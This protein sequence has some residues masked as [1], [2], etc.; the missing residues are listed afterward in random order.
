VG[1]KCVLAERVPA[2]GHRNWIV[3]AES[4]C[5][6]QAR[7]GIEPASVGISAQLRLHALPL[8]AR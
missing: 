1:W 2:F 3:I 7:G 8:A 4:A 6:A 5:P